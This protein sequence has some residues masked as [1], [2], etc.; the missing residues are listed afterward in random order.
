[1]NLEYEFRERCLIEG[2]CNK[3]TCG[4]PNRD[5]IIGCALRFG[6]MLGVSNDNTRDRRKTK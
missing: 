2:N 6:Y 3:C 1:M 5:D 4:C